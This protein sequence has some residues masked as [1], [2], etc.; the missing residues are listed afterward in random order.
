ME[1][2]VGRQPVF[3]RRVEVFGYELF[4]C[5]GL[6]DRY[7]EQYGE[8][9]DAEALYRRLC[10]TGYDES[11]DRPA[12]F[13]A[14]S[15]ELFEHPVPLLPREH[16]IVIYNSGENSGHTDVKN[17]SKIKSQGYRVALG[18]TADAGQQLIE[19]ADIVRLDIGEALSRE[20]QSVRI[21]DN[22]GK[23]LL[24]THITTWD[25][26]KKAYMLGYDY[27]QGS[28]FMK[29]FPG[30][31]SGV[32][33]FNANIL[34][35]ISELGRTEPSFKEI[36]DIIEH[37]LSLSY[38]LLKLINSAYVAPR[39][40]VKTISQA[41]SMLGL[42][43][44]NKFASAILMKEI[45]SPGNTELLRRSLIRGKQ[46]ELLAE[47]RDIPQKGSEAFFTGIF[48]MLDVILNREMQEILEELPLTDTVK[49]ALT[50]EANDMSAL[51]G[52]AADYE[53][54][55]WESF[56]S[57]YNPDMVEQEE[58]MNTYISSLEWAESFDF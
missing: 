8:P 28:F 11:P 35:V 31:V 57:R 53:E 48:S 2:Y 25:D 55:D 22:K 1:Y 4:L 42:N 39:F 13:M 46:L 18:A 49:A 29:P 12:A 50:G 14:Y 24:A 32:R 41:V 54:A 17:L 33:S 19:R 9:E 30:K 15:E 38:K 47:Q 51:L 36:T 23:A 3:N 7:Y 43:E 37:D 44:L 58:L 45:Q 40:K 5:A 34:R 26:Y 56:S 16:V 6:K 20:E 27:F 52:I 10:F 21:K